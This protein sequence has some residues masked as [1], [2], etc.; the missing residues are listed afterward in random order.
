MK[1]WSPSHLLL[2]SRGAGN[3]VVAVRQSQVVL[4]PAAAGTYPG[5][6]CNLDLIAFLDL[7]QGSFLQFTGTM[8]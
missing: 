3:G 6:S 2:A 1:C 5:E 7:S 8:L 4:S